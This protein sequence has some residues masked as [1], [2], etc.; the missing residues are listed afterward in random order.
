MADISGLE[1]RIE[2]LE[3][4]TTEQDRTIEDL[5]NALTDQFK[6]IEALKHKLAQLGAQVEEIGAHP[7]LA[8]VADAPPPHY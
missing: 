7:A 6:Q 2:K 3:M 1:Q 4:L 8:E 5:N